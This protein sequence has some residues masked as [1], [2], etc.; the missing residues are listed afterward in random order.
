MAADV[1]FAHASY[2][3]APKL[4]NLMHTMYLSSKILVKFDEAWLDDFRMEH[5][6]LK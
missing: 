5:V 2:T 3:E 6:E 1:Q 4:I